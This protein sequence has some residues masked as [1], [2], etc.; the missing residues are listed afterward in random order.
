MLLTSLTFLTLGIAH[1]SMALLSLTP[2][3]RAQL[4]FRYRYGYR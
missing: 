1:T 2:K 4:C 3:V